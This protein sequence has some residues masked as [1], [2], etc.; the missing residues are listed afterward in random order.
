MSGPHQ[1]LCP[2]HYGN[3][4]CIQGAMPVTMKN[5]CRCALSGLMSFCYLVMSHI[6]SSSVSTSYELS[7]QMHTW[8]PH[9]Q[10]A[11]TL[12]FSSPTGC[13]MLPAS[14]QLLLEIQSA[15]E[16]GLVLAHGSSF[17][18][19]ISSGQCSNLGYHSQL[20]SSGNPA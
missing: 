10:K 12:H 8:C 3:A 19:H 18:E 9:R 7:T 6:I 13:S 4:C 20:L 1:K 14:L 17:Y 5:L 11:A 15:A 2:E 16:D